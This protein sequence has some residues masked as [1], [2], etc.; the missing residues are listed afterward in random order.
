V[1]PYIQT[2]TEALA[3]AD[4][5]QRK[6]ARETLVL[7]GD[8]A[9]EPLRALLESPQ[10]RLRWEAVRTLVAIVDPPSLE[11][12]VQLLDDPL[13]E[14]RWLAGD[15]LIRLGPR[16]TE[17]V[18]RSLIHGTL[19]KGRREGAHRVLRGLSADNQVLA[20]IVGP[21][22]E[23]LGIE[24]ADRGVIATRAGR[25]LSDLGRVT[26]RLPAVEL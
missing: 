15:G 17:A 20:E 12:F 5:L 7:V 6:R 23:T 2:L 9:V 19:S 21:V 22:I 25:A 18:L 14:V 11:A 1:E 10:K 16:S 24:S 26:G 8:P 3:G 4:G 13:S